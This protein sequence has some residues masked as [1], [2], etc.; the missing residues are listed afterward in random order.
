MPI[1]KLVPDILFP[2]VTLAEA[3]G[4]LAVGGDLRPERLI[5]AYRQGIFPWYSEGEPIL[6]WFISPR[7]VL[8]PEELH[9]ARRLRRTLRRPPFRVRF[10]TAFAAVIG[11]CASSR[12]KTGQATWITE[13]MRCAYSEMH[14]LGYAHSV[15]CWLDDRLVGGLYGLRLGRVFFGESMFSLEDDASKIAFVALVERAMALGIRLIDCQTTTAHLQRFGAREID[16]ALFSQDLRKW[17]DS[18]LP[19]ETWDNENE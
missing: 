15:E 14:R 3:S 1:Y 6:W 9:I 16:G 7:L 18:T 5:A 12:L 10:D 17:V 8:Y 19:D 4:L 13:A 11:Q 2:P